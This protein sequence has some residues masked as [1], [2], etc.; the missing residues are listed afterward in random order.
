MQRR[1]ITT[2]ATSP[3]TPCPGTSLLPGIEKSP[4]V[5]ECTVVIHV[6]DI[7]VIGF[8]SLTINTVSQTKHS[9]ET[10]RQ[11]GIFKVVDYLSVG[12]NIQRPRR[13]LHILPNESP[14]SKGF[15]IH[16]KVSS[17]GWRE[18]MCK[19]LDFTKAALRWQKVAKSCWSHE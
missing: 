6:C 9:E 2:T 15:Y 1:K 11:K 12:W 10:D 17:K 19:Q 7:T 8:N 3:N 18:R 14:H 5:T 16:V 13:P 4:Q